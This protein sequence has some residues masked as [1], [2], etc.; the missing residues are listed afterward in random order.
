MLVPT[1]QLLN[2]DPPK[3]TFSSSEVPITFIVGQLEATRN[4]QK[5]NEIE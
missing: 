4:K 3:S 5:V 2:L 1:L